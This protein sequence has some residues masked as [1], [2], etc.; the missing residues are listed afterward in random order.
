MSYYHGMVRIHLTF[1][2]SL[3]AALRSI[4]PEYPWKPWDFNVKKTHWNTMEN[5]R[6]FMDWFAKENKISTIDDWYKIKIKDVVAKGGKPVLE[7]HR[8]SLIKAL[9]TV[10]LLIEE[11]SLRI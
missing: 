2:G 5:Q 10:Y 4:Y 9:Q 7:M 6:E 1:K 11:F 8:N 3:P